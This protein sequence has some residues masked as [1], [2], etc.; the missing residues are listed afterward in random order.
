MY[1]LLN[2]ISAVILTFKPQI[3]HDCGVQ[4]HHYE[5]GKNT[6][7]QKPRHTV[8]LAHPQ[9]WKRLNAEGE[10][11]IKFPTDKEWEIYDQRKHPTARNNEL[12]RNIFNVHFSRV[13]SEGK[14]RSFINQSNS[15]AEGI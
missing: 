1:L 14:Q 9:L 10:V 12:Q 2:R 11:F 15:F 4:C 5:Y 13:T 8:S 7:G 3:V 6:K